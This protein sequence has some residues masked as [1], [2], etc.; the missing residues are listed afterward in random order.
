M[1]AFLRTANALCL[2]LLLVAA[3]DAHAHALLL[4]SHMASE[5]PT[6]LGMVLHFNSR[7]D[8]GRSRLQIRAGKGALHPLASQPGDDP[9]SLQAHVDGLAPGAYIVHWQVLSVDGHISRGDIPVSVPV[10]AAP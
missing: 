5:S 7:I 1:S 10:P 3:G 4:S 8:A 6:G 2:L 9:A